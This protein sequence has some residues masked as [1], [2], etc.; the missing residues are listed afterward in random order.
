MKYAIVRLAGRQ[1]KVSDGDT[2]KV[3]HQDRLDFEVLLYSDGK[4][5]EVGQPVLKDVVI[6]AKILEQK[7]DDK[8]RV[9]RFKS[10]SRYRKVKGHRQPV[11]LIEI[12]SVGTPV[13]Q[14]KVKKVEP[15]TKKAKPIAKKETK[16]KAVKK[17]VTKKGA[18]KSSK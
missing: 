18:T 11:T 3:T 10:K 6:K 16:A 2:I 7:L 1:F 15:A 5:I 12:E 4:K 8:V 17:T 14:P 13:T 9:A